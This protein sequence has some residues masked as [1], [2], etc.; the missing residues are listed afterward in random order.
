MCEGVARFTVQLTQRIDAA[1]ARIESKPTPAYMG[2][3]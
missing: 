3:F 2:V 1:K